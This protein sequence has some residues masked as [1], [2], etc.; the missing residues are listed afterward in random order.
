MRAKPTEP[1]L[2]QVETT[3]RPVLR[4]RAWLMAG[5]LLVTL[6]VA[7][8]TIGVSQPVG[9]VVVLLAAGG[10]AVGVLVWALRRTRRQRRTYE[11]KLTAWAAER[12]AHTERLRIAR[13]LH[14]LAS[15]GL[16]LITVRAAAARSV[17][18]PAG[19]AER[20]AALTDI[21]HAGRQATTELR[22]LLT[23]LR[24]PGDEAPLRPAE[25]LYDLPRIVDTAHVSGVAA[26]LDVADLGDVSAGTQ[27]TVCAIVREALAN[28]A[29]HAGPTRA[30]VT[31]RRDNDTIVV[32]VTD[33]GPD[34]S[35]VP[36]PG[37][38]TGLA[39]LRERVSALGGSLRTGRFG[40]GYQLTA[41]LPEAADRPEK[42]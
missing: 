27:L 39:G 33:D 36:H 17:T 15:H 13:D 29:R 28:T 12:S 23:V 18:G 35:W 42:Q 31:V 2:A 19:D 26:A 22:R 41:R 1:T 8:S 37:A 20:V 7:L 4:S 5:G 38:G 32:T 9:A 10:G 30:R 25:T 16:G 40:H 11:D 24:S 3:G 14:D 6:L 21:E 34:P